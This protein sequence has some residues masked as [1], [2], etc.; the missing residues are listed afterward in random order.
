MQKLRIQES[1]APWRHIEEGYRR[2]GMRGLDDEQLLNVVTDSALVHATPSRVSKHTACS[3][4]NGDSDFTGA[5]EIV[6]IPSTA[7]LCI[8]KRTWSLRLGSKLHDS[9]GASR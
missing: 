3:P 9:R 5:Y 2:G 8:M 4:Y 7:K 1:Q 6:S